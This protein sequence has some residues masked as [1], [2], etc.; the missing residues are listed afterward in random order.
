VYVIAISVNSYS[1]QSWFII[2]KSDRNN[3]IPT[4]TVVFQLRAA[5]YPTWF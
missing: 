3:N 5:L 4:I 2:G 1:I